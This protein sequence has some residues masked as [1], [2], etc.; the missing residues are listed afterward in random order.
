MLLQAD[1]I[2]AGAERFIA[3]A[4][5][6]V[7]RWGQ[8]VCQLPVLSWMWLRRWCKQW[9]FTPQS[10]NVKYKVSMENVVARLGVLRRSAT[11][12]L[13]LHEVLSGLGRLTFASID[14]KPYW[15]NAFFF[16]GEGE[17]QQV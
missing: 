9:G 6:M 5:C 15:L 11:R 7:W 3:V 17:G 16:G 2:K 1:V 4:A 12:L 10:V 14:E 8:T 13:M